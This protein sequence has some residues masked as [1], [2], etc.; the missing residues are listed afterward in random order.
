MKLLL[1]FFISSTIYSLQVSAQ[2]GTENDPYT[3]LA[4]AWLVPTDGTYHFNINQQSF[5][6]YVEE[7]NGW[8]L[9]ASGNSVTTESLYST[10][11]SLTL[12]SDAILP[13][14]IYTSEFITSVRINATHGPNNPFDVQSSNHNVILNLKNDRTLSVNTNSNDWLGIGTER[15]IRTCASNNKSLSTNIYHACGQRNNM[16]WQ[17]GKF[18]SHEKINYSDVSKNDLN[19]WVKT[20]PLSL[21]ID[22]MYL[23]L[24]HEKNSQEVNIEWQ[25][26]SEHNNDY[27]TLERSLTGVDWET[28]TTTHGAG[29]S[30]RI[31]RYSETDPNPHIGVSYYR[32]KQ[33]DL[34]GK[35]N[36]SPIKSL[37]IESLN[38]YSTIPFPNPTNNQIF[39]ENKRLKLGDITI[40]NTIGENITLLTQ[41]IIV[42]E[43][44]FQIDLSNF[45]TGIYYIKTKNISHKIYKE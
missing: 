8:I 40:Y 3:T 10:V 11:N 13:N 5:S 1:Y 20:T 39:I 24:K 45:K 15:L 9:I 31:I 34:D 26:A 41:P 33:T 25:T 21:P 27:F 43:M 22:L 19:L 12:Q 30:S 17:V 18:S 4:Q 14:T 35:Y 44:K 36:F 2:S 32:L 37:Q 23:N 16:H 28:I 6:T 29:N 42:N 7:G 38:N